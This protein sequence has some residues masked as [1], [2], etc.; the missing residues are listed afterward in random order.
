MTPRYD[1]ASWSTWS[2]APAPTAPAR[3]PPKRLRRSASEA[4]RSR[5]RFARGHRTGRRRAAAA[6]RPP[7]IF[8][9][10]LSQRRG[11]GA[12][13]SHARRTQWRALFA[14]ADEETRGF[15]ATLHPEVRAERRLHSKPR[16]LVEVAAG[17]DGAG[18]FRAIRYRLAFASGRDRPHRTA[19]P[20]AFGPVRPS[21]ARRARRFAGTVP[22]GMR[23][24]GR[25]RLGRRRAARAADR[26]LD[27]AAAGE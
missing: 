22:L 2:R 19:P 16:R 20:A 5:R 12:R 25:D 10:R 1:G 23:A 26:A 18:E 21:Q 8:R 27:R 3:S 13:R 7:R 6:A 4:P 24:G 9:L 15:I 11:A 17:I 14:V